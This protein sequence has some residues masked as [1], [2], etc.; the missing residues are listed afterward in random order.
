MPRTLAGKKR[1]LACSYSP[2][3][4]GHMPRACEVDEC[5][6]PA[7]RRGYCPKHSSKFY[8]YGDPLGSTYQVGP[9]TER[10]AFGIDTSGDGCHPWTR[11]TDSKGYGQIAYQGRQR[12]VTR[13]VM[14][15]GLGRVLS[16]AE[17]VLH[18]CDNPICCRRDHL[19]LGDARQNAQDRKARGR[20][21]RDRTPPKTH[22]KW[23]HEY[24]DAN[25]YMTKTG[26]SCL[27]CRQIRARGE[28]PSLL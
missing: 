12:L 2:W 23:G 8:K 4:Y 6:L 13:L 25:V 20:H 21:W 9:I 28:Q 10:L 27:T 22:C 1:L 18:T 14:E 15:L 19:Y 17:W 7:R 5:V 24:T 16:P 3:Y 11:G 26:R